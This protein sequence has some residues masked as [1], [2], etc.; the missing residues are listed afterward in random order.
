[1]TWSAHIDTVCTTCLCFFSYSQAPFCERPQVSHMANP[2]G[3]CYPCNLIFSKYL[4][5]DLLLLNTLRPAIIFQWCGFAYIYRV[6]VCQIF[7]SCKRHSSSFVND[8]FHPLQLW[9]STLNM[10]PSCR[11]L[12]PPF[13]RPETEV[14]SQISQSFLIKT[15]F[16]LTFAE[17]LWI[18][19]E[20]IFLFLI[21]ITCKLIIPFLHSW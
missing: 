20:L 17:N 1:M 21:R 8:T 15:L 7:I 2:I 9:L 13:S 19:F 12:R 10:H 6:L 16:M 11:L 3:L 18:C 4:V 5:K 14:R